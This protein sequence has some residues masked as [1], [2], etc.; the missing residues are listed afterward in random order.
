VP[1]GADLRADVQATAD[2]IDPHTLMLV[3]SAP[4]FPY[5][6]VDPIEALG[7]L[8]LERGVWLHVDA[9]VGGYLAP[10]AVM[11]GVQVQPFDFAVPGVA[12]ISAD[13]HKYGYAAKGASTL[14][15]RD[16]AQRAHQVFSF[17]AWPAGGMTTATAAGTR[18]GG[19]IASAWAVMHYLGAR[20]ASSC[21]ARSRPATSSTCTAIRGSDS[22]PTAR[23]PSIPSRSGRGSTGAAGSPAW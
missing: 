8:A 4:C 17:D 22:W 6:V 15:H 5:G 23:T 1:V 19:A 13:L 9:C 21:R 16:A 11:N 14:F 2:A 20:R 18:P 12:S 10:F 3:G 7:R